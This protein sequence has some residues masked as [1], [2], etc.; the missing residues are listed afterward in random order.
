L[1]TTFRKTLALAGATAIAV[2]ALGVAAASA[3]SVR[4]AS[5]VSAH[6]SDDVAAP[7]RIRGEVSAER[8][9]LCEVGRTF[10]LF[11]VVGDSVE[12]V[13]AKG[14]PEGNT[15]DFHIADAQAGDDYYVFVTRKV[16]KSDGHKHICKAAIS[17]KVTV[18]PGA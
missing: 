18:G 14:N 7:D 11:K 17:N 10:I 1:T 16:D 12:F 6:Y 3:H 15:F 4:F 2:L 5:T 13:E 9:A 8:P